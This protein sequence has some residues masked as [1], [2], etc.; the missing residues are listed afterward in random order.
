MKGKMPGVSRS[1]AAATC[2]FLI[3]AGCAVVAAHVLDDKI[4]VSAD[5]Y[6]ALDITPPYWLLLGWG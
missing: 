6:D 1:T 4:P 2:V 3:L 5:R